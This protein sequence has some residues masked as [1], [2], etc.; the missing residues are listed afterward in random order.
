ME[1]S[2]REKLLL[3]TYTVALLALILNFEWV[4]NVLG[5]LVGVIKPVLWGI[6]LAFLLNLLMEKVEGGLGLLLGRNKRVKA[7]PGTA[8]RRWLCC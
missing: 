5:T 2:F 8:R 1:K 4:F 3:I 7:R 6:A